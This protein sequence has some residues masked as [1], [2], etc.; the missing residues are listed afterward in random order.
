MSKLWPWS[1]DQDILIKKHIKTDY[2]TQFLTDSMLNDKIKKNQLNKRNI[3]QLESTRVNPLC[4]IP[5]FWDKTTI[6]CQ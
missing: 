4:N 6:S 3:K 5:H 2:E 1:W